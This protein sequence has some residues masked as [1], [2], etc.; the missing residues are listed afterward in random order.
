MIFTIEIA[1]VAFVLALILLGIFLWRFGGKRSGPAL[2]WHENRGM[3]ITWTMVTAV[4]FIGLG[5]HG[6]RIWTRE[7]LTDPSANAMTIEV[8]AQQF[9]WNFRY[10]GPDG[11]FG[12]TRPDKACAELCGMQH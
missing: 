9:A 4:V 2:Y 5:L 7:Y 6:S 10:P 1:G 11:K 3:E 12:R 8:T